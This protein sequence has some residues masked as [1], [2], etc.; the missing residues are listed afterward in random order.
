MSKLSHRDMREI[1]AAAFHQQFGREGELNEVRFAQAICGLET[2]YASTW[3]GAGVGSN[4]MGAVQKGGWTGK[5]FSYF[6]THP[7]PDGTSKSYQIDFRWYDTPFAGA[8]DVIK[9]V[10]CAF[11]IR[12]QALVAAQ[13][14]NVLAFSTALHTPPVYYEGFGASNQERVAHHHNAVLEQLRQQSA[15]LNEPMPELEPLPVLAP[16]LLIGCKGP[17]VNVWQA[18]VGAKVDGDFG[19]ATQVA[20]RAWQHTHGLPETGVVTMVD[21]VVAGLAPAQEIKTS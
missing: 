11:P 2:G 19:G 20:T 15:A 12:K 9:V 16:A 13:R 21:L 17:A 3:K 6:D 14:G 5:V 1:T 8:L 18:I 4:N 7:M 10:Y